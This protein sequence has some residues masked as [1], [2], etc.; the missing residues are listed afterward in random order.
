[1][2]EERT[3]L[4]VDDD[5]CRE[6][7][8]ELLREE[9]YRVLVAS[10]GAAAR[11]M[12]A[13]HTVDLVLLDIVMPQTSGLELLTELRERRSPA[14]LPVVMMSSKDQSAD[15]V[16]ALE[17][18]ANDYVTKPLDL[19]VLLA[20][21]HAQLRL[22]ATSRLG[23]PTNGAF[24]TAGT[25]LDDRYR[26]EEELGAGSFSIVFRAQDLEEN[27]EVAIKLLHSRAGDLQEGAERMER[28]GLTVQRLRHESVVTV[29]RFGKNAQGVAYLVMELLAGK[30]L[31]RLLREEG[32]LPAERC[33]QI[34]FP[35]CELLAQAHALGVVHRDIK[36]AN[37]FL[38]R[39]GA[40][41]VVKV[42]D[43]GIAKSMGPNEGD[44]HLTLAGAILG[45]PAY[46]APERLRNRPYDG[47]ADVYSLGVTLY[48]MLA[49][50][51]PFVFPEDDPLS[52]VAMHLN[53]SPEPL[54]RWRPELPPRLESAVAAALEKDYQQRPWAPELARSLATALG[55][56]LPHGLTPDYLRTLRL[57]A[58]R[59]AASGP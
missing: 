49:G 51:L 36:P 53:E 28:E 46:M 19:P 2:E 30:T 9:G 21:V 18:G 14:E 31:D 58:A 8:S 12:L 42:L 50:R 56:P 27:R 22:K 7:L 17:R 4:V 54:R 59:D 29:H 5:D 37:I 20:R 26:L 11:S 25:L 39:E 40:R 52:V 13:H 24:P 57:E 34:I 3:V 45:S 15:V 38:H 23:T 47:R 10:D 44:R 55:L 6:S 32:S 43:F 48:E 35:V 41:E 16:D 1:M 33:C